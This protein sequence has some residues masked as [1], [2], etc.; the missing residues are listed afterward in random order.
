MAGLIKE[1]ALRRSDELVTNTSTAS[2]MLDDLKANADAIGVAVQVIQIAFIATICGIKT[3][4]CT[5]KG[6]TELF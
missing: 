6:G 3:S 2:S 4:H 1:K 5:K